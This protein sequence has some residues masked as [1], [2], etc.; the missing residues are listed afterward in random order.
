MTSEN[1]SV[2]DSAEIIK[3]KK[4]KKKKM[5]I[6]I[7]AVTLLGAASWLLTEHPELFKKEENKPTTM[8]S[9]ELTTYLFYPIDYDLDITKDSVYMGLNRYIYYKN[10]GETIGITD[11]NYEKY[12]PAVQFFA[13]YFNTII[14]G[15]ANAHNLLYTDNYYKTNEEYDSFPPQMLY[16]I[17]IEQL[18]MV[19]NSDK[20]VTYKFNVSY[21]IHKNTGTFRNDIDSDSS[22]TLYYELIEDRDGRVL[23]DRITYYK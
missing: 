20:T 5:L 1:N 8:Y 7:L 9:D 3:A 11:G 13:I 19:E 23:I 4:A 2:R 15:S 14:N 17:L 10:G 16:D 22:R 12:G 21:K 18:A 6:G